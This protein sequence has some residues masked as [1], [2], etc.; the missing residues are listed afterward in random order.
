MDRARVALLRRQSRD[1]SVAAALEGIAN[2]VKLAG[3]RRILVKPNFV[4]VDRQLAATHVD[5]VRAVLDFL[6]ARYHG[7]IAVAQGA[8][9]D[10]A[11]EGLRNTATLVPQRRR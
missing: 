3:V 11:R 4:V 10:P 5:A 9:L 8:A 6:R 2:D 7:P 1:E